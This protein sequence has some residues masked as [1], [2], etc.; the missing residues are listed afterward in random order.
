MRYEKELIRVRKG[1]LP[2][3]CQNACCG[4][5]RACYVPASQ[6]TLETPWLTHPQIVRILE[7]FHCALS[8]VSEGIMALAKAQDT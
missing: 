5:V 6:C 4:V 2:G 1:D 3:Q 7:N 8:S